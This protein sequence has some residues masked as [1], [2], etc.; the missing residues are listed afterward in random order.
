MPKLAAPRDPKELTDDA[1]AYIETAIAQAEASITRFR[2]ALKKLRQV[3]KP[4]GP[5]IGLTPE[6]PT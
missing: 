4:A 3:Q 6:Q 2:K 5:H 1:I